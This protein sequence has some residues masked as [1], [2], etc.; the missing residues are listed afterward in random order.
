MQSVQKKGR[1]MRVSRVFGKKR[2]MRHETKIETQMRRETPVR[3][4]GKKEYEFMG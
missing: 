2:K 4:Y 1:L 3:R